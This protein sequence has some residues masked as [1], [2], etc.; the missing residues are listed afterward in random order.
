VYSRPDDGSVG[1]EIMLRILPITDNYEV[2]NLMIL[3]P[4]DRQEDLPVPYCPNGVVFLAS[5]KW[6]PASSSPRLYYQPGEALSDKCFKL[7]FNC[8]FKELYH[9]RIQTGIEERP[10]NYVRMRKGI[11][12]P[13]RSEDP[14]PIAGFDRLGITLPNPGVDIA[15]DLPIDELVFLQPE[16]DPSHT[17]TKLWLRFLT[18][19]LQKCGNE[20]RGSSYCR[21]TMPERESVTIDTYQD[22]DLSK[23]FNKVQ[24]KK[25]S[26]A[27][28]IRAFAIFWPNKGHL[29]SASAQHFKKMQYYLEWKTLCSD[30]SFSDVV[31]LQHA[32][33]KQFTSM[34]WIPSPGSDRVWKYDPDDSYQRL[35]PGLLTTARAPQVLML[36]GATPVWGQREG[37]MDYVGQQRTVEEQ[38]R[39][40][41]HGELRPRRMEAYMAMR[42]E[43]EESSG[44]SE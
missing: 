41:L 44:P 16:E 21:L 34:K 38:P 18:D 25:A 1:R 5:L 17:I 39:Q 12:R 35:P 6:P 11:T 27:D 15:D 3:P 40:G 28:V 7:F 10:E 2:G 30:M 37:Q 26:S 22:V 8:T 13:H 14:D 42:Q 33:F 43:E 23:V 32:L 36:S 4:Q 29:L 9:K 20:K 24:W 31:K 19:I